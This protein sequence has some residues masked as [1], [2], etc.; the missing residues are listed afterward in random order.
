MDH[1]FGYN[2]QSRPEHFLARDELCWLLTDVV[3]KG[4]NLLLNV[5]PRGIDATI[6]DEQR[7][8][9]RLAGSVVR[10]PPGRPGRHPA[11]GPGRY[12]PR[13]PGAPVRYTARD[14]TVFAF[15]RGADGPVTLPDVAATPST[16][17]TTVDG[18]CG[19]GTTRPTG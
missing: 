10:P 8:A 13:P 17:V 9:P 5:G 1:S 12:A 19:R 11:L 7:R 14:D 16:G 18:S 15:V 6:P 2:A 4:G 3:A